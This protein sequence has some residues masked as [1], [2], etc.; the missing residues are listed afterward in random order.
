MK[1]SL[2][3]LA[4]TLWG[5]VCAAPAAL[6]DEI[7]EPPAEAVESASA[8]PY[9][10]AVSRADLSEPMRA[11]GESFGVQ[12]ELPT[13]VIELRDESFHLLR[14]NEG[15]LRKLE[16]LGVINRRVETLHLHMPIDPTPPGLYEAAVRCRD[17]DEWVSFNAI[18]PA[19][20]KDI[21][22]LR[23]VTEHSYRGA[24]ALLTVVLPDRKT[25]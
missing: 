7:Y 15:F 1:K 24:L 8:A 13:G 19:G 12:S 14:G 17:N 4:L 22:Y 25:I 11:M 18:G 2:T 9:Y 20:E 3:R 10:D 21:V 5:L 6:A 23:R 16:G